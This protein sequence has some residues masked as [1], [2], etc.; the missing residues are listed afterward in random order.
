MAPEGTNAVFTPLSKNPSFHTIPKYEEYV[1]FLEAVC[2]R[3]FG[4]ASGY[5]PT[6]RIQLKPT[7]RRQF[8]CFL[9]QGNV[10]FATFNALRWHA[11]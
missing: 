11:G 3:G 6:H 2:C 1:A 9:R 5:P 7:R 8:T 4:K 10:N